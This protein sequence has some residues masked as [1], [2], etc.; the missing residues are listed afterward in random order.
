MDERLLIQ[1]L[2]S[3]ETRE[4]AFYRLVE[5]YKQRLYWHIRGIVVIH[6]DADDVLQNTFIKVYKNI[7]AF[8]GNSSLFSWMYRIAT[9]ESLTHLKKKSREKQ[10][11]DGEY[12]GYLS[13]RLESDP[14]YEGD[15]MQ[16]EFMKAVNRL[17][18]KQ[19][20]VFQMRY[21]ENMKFSEIAEI[22]EQSEGGLKANYHH[23]VKKIKSTIIS[24]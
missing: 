4:R 2:Q 18:E 23:A 6:E 14:Y 21:F 10:M 20:L 12:L 24:E 15:E 7:H 13:D 3:P 9:N 5:Q 19:R 8:R 17:P 22:L 1:Q 11:E 16:R